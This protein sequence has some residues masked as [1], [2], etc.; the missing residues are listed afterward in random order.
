[1]KLIIRLR[2]KIQNFLIFFHHPLS[3]DRKFFTLF[4][5]LIL[6][7]K[8]IFKNRFIV[9]WLNGLRFYYGKDCWGL[10]GEAYYG[11]NEIKEQIF[12]LHFLRK[13]DFFLD[14]GANLGSYTLLASGVV[15]AK[16]LAVEPSTRTFKSLKDNISLNNLNRLVKPVNFALGKNNE[17][18]FFS[19][20]LGVCNRI[21]KKKEINKEKFE[22]I[23]S[24]KLDTLINRYKF[25]PDLIK[26]DIEGNEYNLLNNQKNIISLNKKPIII[27]EIA[28]TSNIHN[29]KNSEKVLKFFKDYKY[30]HYT[31]DYEKRSLI[32]INK[33]LLINFLKKMDYFNL[34]FIRYGSLNY[35]NK[36]VKSAKKFR[37]KHKLF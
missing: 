9:D 32:K 8:K 5:I 27:C 11:L 22:K 18:V 21:L 3:K 29:S 20:D 17:D 12:L 35:V 16:T 36:K 28:K 33:K 19:K 37:I 24:L 14:I 4:K 26:I 34:I 25:K 31:Y 15:K 1:M 10:S 7:I 30:D 23:K 13:G 6:N 2:D